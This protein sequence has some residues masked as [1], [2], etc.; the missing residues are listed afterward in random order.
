MAAGETCQRHGARV[1]CHK[2]RD[3]NRTAELRRDAERY[4]ADAGYCDRAKAVKLGNAVHGPD[5]VSGASRVAQFSTLPRRPR[6][7]FRNR[8]GLRMRRL[9]S[10]A[11]TTRASDVMGSQPATRRQATSVL[12]ISR[13]SGER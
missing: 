10:S 1:P 8:R 13:S 9:K 12:R 4:R 2:C 5:I 7:G 6:D 3:I 11:S